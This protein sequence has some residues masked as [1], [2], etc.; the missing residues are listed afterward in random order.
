MFGVLPP[1]SPALAPL[2]QELAAA[3]AA[4]EHGEAPLVPAFDRAL[5]VDRVAVAR[6]SQEPRRGVDDR[7]AHDPVA[8]EELALRRQDLLEVHPARGVEPAEVVRVEHDVRGVAVAPLDEDA[9]RR[10][11]PHVTPPV[12]RRS[13]PP[14]WSRRRAS[15]RRTRAASAAGAARTRRR[16]GNGAEARSST[17]RSARRAT[18]AAARSRSSDRAGPCGP[19]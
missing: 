15:S 17:T 19:T 2:A 7:E 10:G 6:R 1:A 12:T 9:Q 16:R 5:D 11:E 14:G 4:M 13:S 3:H 18:P 8:L